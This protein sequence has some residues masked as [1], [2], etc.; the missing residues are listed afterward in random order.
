MTESARHYKSVIPNSKGITLS[1]APY[2]QYAF[3]KYDFLQIQ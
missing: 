2:N 3:H 1:L